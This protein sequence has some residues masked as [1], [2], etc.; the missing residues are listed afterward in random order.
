[1]RKILYLIVIPLAVFAF[2]CGY[3]AVLHLFKNTGHLTLELSNVSRIEALSGEEIE[4]S[5]LGRQE[6]TAAEISFKGNVTVKAA[7]PFIVFDEEYNAFYTN[8]IELIPKDQKEHTLGLNNWPWQTEYHIRTASDEVQTID[9]EL[10]YSPDFRDD[11][12]FT[13]SSQSMTVGIE[14]ILSFAQSSYANLQSLDCTAFIEKKGK[15]IE[16]RPAIWPELKDRLYI[17]FEISSADAESPVIFSARLQT[18]QEELEDKAFTIMVFA[19]SSF[20]GNATGEIDWDYGA[21]HE[22]QH[23]VNSKIQFDVAERLSESTQGYSSLMELIS[24]S[25]NE[26]RNLKMRYDAEVYA[27]KVGDHSLFPNAWSF[28][29]KNWHEATVLVLFLEI[30]ALVL[31]KKKEEQQ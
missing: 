21:Y 23:R 19:P 24:E 22:S 28:F 4:M 20:C 3:F 1:M 18:K 17:D 15:Q 9:S 16:V 5:F 25:D 10:S 7:S 14:S 13:I 31:S 11:Y 8:Q 30:V 2:L 12:L 29:S 27:A 26:K 6:E